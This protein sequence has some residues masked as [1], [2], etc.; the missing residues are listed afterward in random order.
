[1]NKNMLIGI[2]AILAVLAIGYWVWSQNASKEATLPSVN[3]SQQNTKSTSQATQSVVKVR[4]LS[5]THKNGALPVLKY[6]ISGKPTTNTYI[7]IV[8]KTSGK[9]LWGM[10]ETVG[11]R[12]LDLNTLS[13]HGQDMVTIPEGEYFLQLL[14]WPQ[15][16]VI[17]ESESF[18]VGSNANK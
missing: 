14:S 11:V 1:M 8:G 5:L 9:V 3:E 18:H 15:G 6:E 7:Q 13:K 16:T 4:V 10:E 17:T 2:V 12:D